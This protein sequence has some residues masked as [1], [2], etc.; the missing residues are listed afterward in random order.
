MSSDPRASREEFLAG[1]GKTLSRISLYSIN[2]P[3]TVEAIR[4][5][6][7]RLALGLS[8]GDEMTISYTDE[9]VLLDGNPLAGAGPAEQSL[10]AIFEKYHLQSLTFRPGVTQEELVAFYKL[11]TLRDDAIKD[12]EGLKKFFESEKL[13]HIALDTAFYA[14]VGSPSEG[15]GPG[16]AG[17]GAEQAAGEGTGEAASRWIKSLET[18]PLDALLREIIRKAVP[19]PEDQKRVYDL[20]VSQIE[21]DLKEKVKKATQSLER[22]KKVLT[23]ETVRTETVVSNSA[24]GVVVVDEKG[25]IVMMNP[26]AERIYG[27]SLSELK[28]KPLSATGHE[29]L[30][31]TLAKDI[32]NSTDKD[33]T[34]E[35]DI[36]SNEHTLSVIRSSSAMI[37]NPEGKIVGIMS[38]LNDVAKQR[39]LQRMQNDFLAHVTHELRNPLTSIRASL[40]TIDEAGPVTDQQKHL[41][42]LAN[43]SI[44]RLSRLINDL[45]DTAKMEA[46][47]LSIAPKAVDVGRLLQESVA[48]LESWARTK[49]ISLTAEVQAGMPPALAD[50]D[51]ITQVLVNLFSNSIK[52]TPQGGKIRVQAARVGTLYIKISVTDTGP[53]IPKDKQKNLFEKFYQL[54]QTQK[55]EMPGTGLGLHIA[56]KIV[57]AHSGQIGVDSDEGKGSTFYFT[58][59]ATSEPSAKPAAQAVRQAQAERKG[60]F[61]RLFGK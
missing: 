36:L 35:V 47:K 60:W 27:A 28:G 17:T 4:N 26:A 54:Q 22:D 29:Y 58:L 19:N 11:L 53:G 9:K 13:E 49:Q 34:R 43:R 5:S 56:K 51:R 21:N 32:V 44:E 59:P 45:L 6:F 48:S 25:H 1:L 15:G 41:I 46:G 3:L 7:D 2:H 18:M 40:G 39:E 50:P 55:S 23:N 31:I 20:I 10:A 52:F 57:E 16:G 33:F 8:G 14:R 30:M 61:S 42:D 12:A 37:Q 24:E 38:I